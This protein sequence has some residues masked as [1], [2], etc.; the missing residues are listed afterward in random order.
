MK[1][2]ILAAGNGRRIRCHAATLKPLVEVAGKTLL[3]HVLHSL[4]AAGADEIVVIIN[5][6]SLAVRDHIAAQAWPFTVR[7]MIETT[8]ASM[9]SFLRLM[10]ELSAD[11]AGGP[12]L[13]STVDTIVAPEDCREFFQKATGQR[14][15]AVTLALTS[16][17]DD[18]KPLLARVEKNSS[19]ITALGPAA[20]GSN[21][22]TAG[23][24]AVCPSILCEAE[25]ARRDGLDS[26]RSFLARLLERG[27]LIRGV[28]IPEAIDVDY[29]TDVEKAEALLESL[30]A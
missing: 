10:E 19:R 18:E 16:M 5:E 30:P 12:F 6:D 20:N 8:P 9:H 15:A 17:W 21:L 25:A 27:H 23:L 7:W 11:G 26:L 1:A 2:G 13:L 14:D 29:I 24:Y 3:E 28:E 22:A 4:H